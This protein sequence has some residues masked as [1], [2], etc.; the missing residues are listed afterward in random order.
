MNGDERLSIGQ[1]LGD[2]GSRYVIPIYQ[3]EYAWG[4]REI[5]QL[6]DDVRDM[7]RASAQHT[8][9][10]RY[11]IG[12]LVVHKTQGSGTAHRDEYEVVDGQQR[13]TTLFLIRCVAERLWGYGF[14]PEPPAG[15]LRFDCREES[16][17]LLEALGSLGHDPQA[18][19]NGKK[20]DQ[21]FDRLVDRFAVPCAGII[22]GYETIRV[23]LKHSGGIGDAEREAYLR[24]LFCNVIVFRSELPED[25]DLNHYFEIMNTRG[26]QL[27]H[28]EVVKAMLMSRLSDDTDART[29]FATIWDACA[30]MN[31]YVQS[32]IPPSVRGRL[33]GDD[34]CT[35]QPD[36]LDFTSLERALVAERQPDGPERESD[37]SVRDGSVRNVS[38][39]NG[40][41]Q[42]HAEPAVPTRANS[43]RIDF[44]REETL[45]DVLESPDATA[46]VER[47]QAEAPHTGEDGSRYRSIVRF[48]TFLLIVL[49]LFLHSVD[50]QVTAGAQ[51]D[52]ISLDDKNLIGFFRKAFPAGH[53]GDAQ[54]A[55]VKRF[56][57]HLLRCRFLFDNYVIRT[58]DTDSVAE[59]DVQ[60]SLRRY[61]RYGKRSGRNGFS[62]A[63]VSSFAG[64]D[65]ENGDSDEEIDGT[66]N[67]RIRTLQSM[68][69]VTYTAQ[70]AKG[71][72]ST[73]L[74]ILLNQTDTAA[75]NSAR[76]DGNE[77]LR[78]L[79]R[80]A[81]RRFADAVRKGA[82]RGEDD[83]SPSESIVDRT[84]IANVA[85]LGQGTPW[86]VLNYIDYVL[87]VLSGNVPDE[88][89]ADGSDG[90]SAGVAVGM[91]D[92]TGARN[93]L[94]AWFRTLHGDSAGFSP[95]DYR[96]HYWDSVEHFSP[97]HPE[98][99]DP[100]DNV[101]EIGNLCM[102]TRRENSRRNNLS[103]MSKISEFD[104]PSK[105]SSQSLKF[106]Y[107]AAIARRR[108]TWGG[109]EISRET[110]RFERL[111][112]LL[113]RETPFD[114]NESWSRNHQG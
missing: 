99:A 72:V 28:H 92:R 34:W 76:P 38:I 73:M 107:M 25:T 106:Q 22:A 98:N 75:G 49:R 15:M 67:D 58:E 110:L 6:L 105:R 74:D 40:L 69:Q 5:E 42:A 65:D 96:F 79:Q 85:R 11:Y 66:L 29:A 23:W 32:S 18:A 4:K 12:S 53:G 70:S 37:G 31:R 43:R 44:P 16:T 64:N 108:G 17:R 97:Q 57:A 60:W 24:F 8:D 71:F 94:M 10:T 62:Y 90:V 56:A 93:G 63:Y 59:D 80:Y 113:L 35:P 7:F 21:E 54:S 84:T 81:H 13:L 36:C 104:G 46:D 19:D 109:D 48:P 103:A 52:D 26:E 89:S 14:L 20:T 102:M 77:F 1:L 83:E 33:F 61:R 41:G 30:D 39:R 45:R 2:S 27:R 87:W 100:V 78:A 55:M 68:F 112:E 51:P 88:D 86:I 47:E 3:R 114:D 82:R 9:R 111:L 91:P 50:D 101:D 95:T